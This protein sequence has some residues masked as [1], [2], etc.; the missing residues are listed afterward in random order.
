MSFAITSLTTTVYYNSTLLPYS[1]PT[2]SFSDASS[3]TIYD[4][5]NIHPGSYYSATVHSGLLTI[6]NIQ[7]LTEPLV[8]DVKIKVEITPDYGLN[9]NYLDKFSVTNYGLFLN[10]TGT[11]NQ[12]TNCTIVTA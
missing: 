4:I 1:T 8:Y 12:F 9:T 11:T 3:I 10:A 5:S 2:Y 7:V 6:S